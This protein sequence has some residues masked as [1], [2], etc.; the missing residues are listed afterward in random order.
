MGEVCPSMTDFLAST[1][2]DANDFE[3]GGIMLVQKIMSAAR[4]HVV[5]M[6]CAGCPGHHQKKV[7]CA[8]AAEEYNHATIME[9]YGF[10]RI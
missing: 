4:T 1:G 8:M 9:H 5:M 2:M 3:S 6:S 10:V 7:C